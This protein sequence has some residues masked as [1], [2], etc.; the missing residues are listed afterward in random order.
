MWLNYDAV[1]FP[2]FS[3]AWVLCCKGRAECA[4]A[5]YP[6]LPL[7]TGTVMEVSPTVRT[8]G[9]ESVKKK[10]PVRISA[11]ASRYR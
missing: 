2:F 8:R 3:S 11:M 1:C 10:L 5:E 7:D 9:T 4:G 6:T